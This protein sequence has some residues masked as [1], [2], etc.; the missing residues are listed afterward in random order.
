MKNAPKGFKRYDPTLPPVERGLGSVADIYV[1]G[2]DGKKRAI[3]GTP[4]KAGGQSDDMVR[5]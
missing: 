4:E 3:R 2:T 1:E 5:P